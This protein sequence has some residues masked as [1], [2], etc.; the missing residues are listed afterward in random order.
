MSSTLLAL[1]PKN[2]HDEACVTYAALILLDSGS[3]I[4]SAKLSQIL[5]ESGNDVESFWCPIFAQMLSSMHAEDLLA[6]LC[7]AIAPTNA[8]VLEEKGKEKAIELE[9]KGKENLDEVDISQSCCCFPGGSV[10]DGY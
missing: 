4:T 5:D 1:L 8:I 7:N 10:K 2:Q 9:E 6:L 3:E